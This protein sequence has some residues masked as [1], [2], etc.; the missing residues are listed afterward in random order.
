MLF[1][2]PRSRY[3]SSMKLRPA[4]GRAVS[5][6]P[7]ES[8]VFLHGAGF[9]ANINFQKASPAPPAGYVIDSGLVFG[10][11]GNG[12][13]YGW[14][15]DNTGAARD[16]NN[17]ISPD[18]RY[19]TLTHTQLYGNRTWEI[20][21][22]KG[23]YS[24]RVVG[25]DPSAADSTLGFNVEGTL[26]VSGATTTSQRWREGTVIV[27]V[28][29]GRLTVSNANGAVNN[30]INF[31]DIDHA[32]VGPTPPTVSVAVGDGSAGEQ[33]PNPGTFVVSRQGDLAEALTVRYAVSG[34]A[35]AGADYQALGGSVVIPAGA[36]SALVAVRP[37]DD[38]A[39]EGDEHVQVTLSE[40]NAYELSGAASATL[41]LSDNDGG[42]PFSARVNFQ[43]AGATVPSGYLADTGLIFGDRGNGL[44]FGWNLH[45]RSNARDRNSSRS[46]DQRYDTLNHMHKRGGG[47]MWEIAVPNGSYTVRIVAGDPSAIDSNYAIAVEGVLAVSGRPTSSLRWFEGTKTVQVSDGRLT[48][49]NAAGSSNN[50]IAFVDIGADASPGLPQVSLAA[51]DASATEA[52]GDR[53]TF[54]LTRTGPT[55]RALVVNLTRGGS[56]TNNAD[57]DFLSDTH[58]IPAGAASA[59][60][61]VWPIQDSLVEGTETVTFAVAAAAGYTPASSAPATVSITDDD[62][63]TGTT[64]AWR[65]V[66][67]V[68]VGRSEAAGAAVGGKL[69]LFSG[70]VDNTFT[71]TRRADVFDPEANAWRQIRDMPFGASH[72]G[73]TVIGNSIYFAGGYPARS[74]TGQTFATNRVFR[75]DTLTDAYADLPSLPSSRGGGAL[76]A[77]GRELHFFGGS[78]AARADSGS[79]WALNLDNLAAGWVTRAA[80]PVATNHVAGTVLDGKIYAIGGQ[81]FQDAAAVQR[82]EV[83]V[84]DP[85][86]DRWTP[87]APLPLARS[88]ITSATLI[89]NGRII[90]LGGLGPGNTVLRNVSSYD[91]ATNVWTNLTQLPSGRLSGVSDVLP[92]GRIVFT[93]GAGGGF[94]NT[95][96]VGQFV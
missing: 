24:V 92:D 33:G 52:A 12:L 13:A 41:R 63:P 37:I 49:T 22:P 45:N 76:V 59:T 61:N 78:D 34:S 4:G 32:E 30:K 75:Y 90:V 80:L 42:A 2:S 88:H 89:R 53:G 66:T 93:T 15:A 56:A 51:T 95:T 14:N 58:T 50:K 19:D 60:F 1:S 6:E 40:S 84:Y 8:R 3:R 31:I 57:Y 17:A 48:V 7:L 54:T 46:P 96:W 73:T 67:P 25:G 86:T 38:T 83:Q 44:S 16:R 69:Y 94:R 87:R 27:Q 74:T 36:A 29:D 64:L 77:L 20:A 70:Y 68:T 62:Q 21:V 82:A 39:V 26:A 43:P 5:L 23:S 10:D 71:P 55:D 47:S 9:E 35:T 11:R 79:H 18:Q 81:Q 28:N 65:E 85:A 91:P 72:I